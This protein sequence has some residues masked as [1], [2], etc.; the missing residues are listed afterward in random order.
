[1]ASKL[2]FLLVALALF[3]SFASSANPVCHSFTTGNLTYTQDFNTLENGGPTGTAMPV[4]FGFVETGTNA[5]SSYGVGTGSG[6]AGDT[7][8]VGLASPNPDFADR[9][10]GGLQSGALVPIIG[11]CF[12]N[13]TG[14]AITR[15][16]VQ[17]DGEQWRLGSSGR[18]DRIDFQYSLDATSL[19]TGTWVDVDALD[20]STPVSVDTTGPKNGNNPFYRVSGIASSITSLNI[21]VGATFYLRYQDFN[22]SGSDDVLAV[23]NFSLT[24]FGATGPSSSNLSISGRVVR[25]DG[26]GIGGAYVRL[27]GSEGGEQMV[28]TNPFGYYRF[29]GLAAGRTF[30]LTTGAKRF[31][32]AAP[33]RTV[34]LDEDIAGLDFVSEQ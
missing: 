17:Y 18:T 24:I 26:R 6:T 5:N 7:W 8:S 1:M 30:F 4:G 11:G 16:D 27:A 22:A 32:F 15:F 25:A 2:M 9:A 3:A 31:T 29:A 10:F 19:T 28:L 12:V 33:T 20:F 13:N 34:T 21:P 14:A 23:D